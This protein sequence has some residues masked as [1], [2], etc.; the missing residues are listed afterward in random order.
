MPGHHLALVTLVQQALFPEEMQPGRLL[1]ARSADKSMLGK[2][3]SGSLEKGL[4]GTYDVPSG[5]AIA[6]KVHQLSLRRKKPAWATTQPSEDEEP[7]TTAESHVPEQADSTSTHAASYAESDHHSHAHDEHA[8]ADK[9]SPVTV[10]LEAFNATPAAAT[11]VD[12]P[13]HMIQHSQHAEIHDDLRTAHTTSGAEL[14]VKQQHDTTAQGRAASNSPTARAHQKHGHDHVPHHLTTNR[15]TLS[16]VSSVAHEQLVN[17]MAKAR[18]NSIEKHVVQHDMFQRASSQP[19]HTVH[20]PD[21]FPES[22]Q[23]PTLA[24]ILRETAV[25]DDASKRQAQKAART[26]D[27]ALPPFVTTSSSPQSTSR[28]HV[29]GSSRPSSGPA[30]AAGTVT[31]HQFASELVG[32]LRSTL[33]DSSPLSSPRQHSHTS[34]LQPERGRGTGV[35]DAFS[36]SST[37]RA[38]GSTS[39]LYGKQSM[40]DSMD[41]Q[42][43]AAAHGYAAQVLHPERSTDMSQGDA[44]MSQGDAQMSQGT[45][46]S[47]AGSSSRQSADSEVAAAFAEELPAAMRQ[48]QSG[49]MSTSRL[50]RFNSLTKGESADGVRHGRRLSEQHETFSPQVDAHSRKLA[51]AVYEQTQGLG[52]TPLQGRLNYLHQLGKVTLRD[53]QLCLENLPRQREELEFAM[54]TFAPKLNKRPLSE[55]WAGSVIERSQAWQAR[56]DQKVHEA[57]DQDADKDL[58]GCTFWPDVSASSR[59]L[60][61]TQ[62][63]AAMTRSLPEHEVL[64]YLSHGHPLPAVEGSSITNNTFRSMYSNSMQEL[65]TDLATYISQMKYYERMH[66]V[67]E[68]EQHIQE[69]LS[70]FDGSKWVYQ[71]TKPVAPKLGQSAREPI[72]SLAPPVRLMPGMIAAQHALRTEA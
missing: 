65:P 23:G 30:S 11:P 15:A 2:G 5:A 60:H 57:R 28:Q 26:V 13:G 45:E 8:A 3:A 18:Q 43:R 67:K 19:A 38:G 47:R 9:P 44:E 64:K 7:C 69:V 56:R 50:E 54:C 32:S 34:K 22:F 4:S 63:V 40:A 49:S 66:K 37:G 17:K 72:P 24:A 27:D 55:E 36:P 41:A 61:N 39:S 51:E 10:M 52:P 59:S 20:R 70:K 1:S 46:D 71:V 33:H 35:H 29:A 31:Q 16:R 21:E 68:R 42:W 14:E 12:L 58:Q 53:R 6:E 48:Q 25:A 62:E